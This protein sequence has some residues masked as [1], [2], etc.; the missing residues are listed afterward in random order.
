M[1]PTRALFRWGLPCLLFL[2]LSFPTPWA[3]SFPPTVVL[4]LYGSGFWFYEADPAG[5]RQVEQE[6]GV[7][8]SAL[9]GW[10]SVSAGGLW[11]STGVRR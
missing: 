1:L 7:S 11:Q 3:L 2:F 6:P 8:A 10:R 5:S 9:L 4:G